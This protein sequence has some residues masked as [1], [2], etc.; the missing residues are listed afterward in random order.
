MDHDGKT[1]FAR[2]G[3]DMPIFDD[4]RRQRTVLLT[5]R[6]R[7]GTTVGTPVNIA[8]GPDGRAYFRTWSA[9]GKAKRMRNFPQVQIAPCTAR[10]K[11]TGPQRQATA[12]LL[13]GP[14]AAVAAKALAA[15]YPL[16]QGLLVPAVHRLTKKTTVH[17]EL[18]PP[19][20]S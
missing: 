5:T 11:A 9:T 3:G 2:A 6:K 4:Y 19:D 13:S 18:L 1:V 17:Y 12:V 16:L 7:D 10:G 15:K 14:E 20:V 8:L